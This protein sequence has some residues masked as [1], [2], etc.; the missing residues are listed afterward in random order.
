M[1]C[2]AV[3]ATPMARSCSRARDAARSCSC[4]AAAATWIVAMTATNAG[5]AAGVIGAGVVRV[6]PGGGRRERNC[7][8]EMAPGRGPRSSM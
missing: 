1:R 3:R 5:S 2:C 8:G 7:V 6:K 4:E